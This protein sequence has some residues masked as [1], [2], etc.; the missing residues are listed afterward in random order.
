MLFP[1]RREAGMILAKHLAREGVRADGVVALMRGGL[2][3]ALEIARHLKLPLKILT[4]RKLSLPG[5]EEYALG[6]VTRDILIL[7]PDVKD[8]LPDDVKAYLL[9]LARRKR[10]EIAEREH[11][12]LHHFP[13]D[14]RDQ[15]LTIQP[16]K[17]YL[18][19]DDGLATG[20][21]MLAAAEHVT[22]HEAT[23]LVAVPVTSRD[24]YERLEGRFIRVVYT[25]MPEPFY[26]VGQF[27]EDFHQVE[28][29][30]VRELLE[31]YVREVLPSLHG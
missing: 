4:V 23:P 30:E 27:Y 20:T 21:S 31:E 5:N 9:S 28:D 15:L 8:Q 26:A 7:N 16:G 2:P 10:G 6:A 1:D 12:W 22:H 19:V 13:G 14:V 29:D 24:A 3:V 17:T 18:L 11:A 25:A